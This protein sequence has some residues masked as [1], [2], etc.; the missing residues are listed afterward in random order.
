MLDEVQE[1]WN[2]MTA[3]HWWVV[4][5]HNIS[6]MIIS[7]YIKLFSLKGKE[8]ID[9]GCAG[10]VMSGY[11]SG[12]GRVFGIDTSMEGLNMCR[13]N[14]IAVAGADAS[15]MPF[16]DNFFSA[17]VLLDVA[18]HIENDKKL[19]EEINRILKPG[20]ILFITVPANMCL[21]GPHDVVY[22][23]KR[24]YTKKAIVELGFKSNFRI[25][26]ITYMHPFVLPIMFILRYLSRMKK[27]ALGV[28]DD[29][30]SF[31]FL[32]DKLI[33]RI[34]NF[35]GHML[36]HINFPAGVSILCVME[37]I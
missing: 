4:G 15:A 20:G 32:L 36:K 29:F 5:N 23:H 19:F 31:G 33:L 21:W 17:A 10:G 26:K 6:K 11:L 37:K 22:G 7:K 8:F 27:T 34:L 30:I 25:E 13:D 35:E 14:N 18:E 28:K 2:K 24:R 9:I 1:R 3:A 16:K 12:Y